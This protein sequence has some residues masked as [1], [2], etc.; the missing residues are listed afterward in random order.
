MR[1]RPARLDMVKV[2]IPPNYPFTAWAVPLLGQ[3][4]PRAVPG[5][6]RHIRVLQEYPEIG[7]AL[8]RVNLVGML[9]AE[10]DN[11]RRTDPWPRWGPLRIALPVGRFTEQTPL[12]PQPYDCVT[13]SQ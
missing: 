6:R 11:R 10:G 1:G 4:L 8:L 5:I 12:K 2:G 9:P 13:N 7:M 3:V